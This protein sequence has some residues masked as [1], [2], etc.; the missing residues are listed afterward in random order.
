[1]NACASKEEATMNKSDTKGGI[2]MAGEVTG[3]CCGKQTCTPPSL[4]NMKASAWSSACESYSMPSDIQPPLLK[5]A[6]QQPSQFGTCVMH[7][8]L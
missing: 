5:H 8:T 7:A 1:M 3:M 2:E 6:P 4:P